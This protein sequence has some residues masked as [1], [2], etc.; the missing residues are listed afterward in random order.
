[1]GLTKITEIIEELS[2]KNR[3]KKKNGKKHVV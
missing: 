2:H 1:V 3:A